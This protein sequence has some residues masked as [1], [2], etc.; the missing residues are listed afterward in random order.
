MF[1]ALNIKQ[2]SDQ[3]QLFFGQDISFPD[4]VERV[5]WF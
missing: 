3:N 2:K 5:F 1:A 4:H